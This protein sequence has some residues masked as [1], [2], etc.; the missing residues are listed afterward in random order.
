MM[1][2]E[3]AAL[4]HFGL[5]VRTLATSLAEPPL[6]PGRLFATTMIWVGVI[7]F[8]LV[9]QLLVSTWRRSARTHEP[10]L[11]DG[12]A[13]SVSLFCLCNGLMWVLVSPFSL[14]TMCVCYTDPRARVFSNAGSFSQPLTIFGADPLTRVKLASRP[15]TYALFRRFSIALC[16]LL[17]VAPCCLLS[18][19]PS[20]TSLLIPHNLYFILRI[21]SRPNSRPLQFD[22]LTSGTA[23]ALFLLGHVLFFYL[24]RPDPFRICCRV[25]FDIACFGSCYGGCAVI[26]PMRWIAL[27]L[28]WVE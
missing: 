21:L 15:Y 26:I 3:D 5:D 23:E 18:R 8:S 28:C 22:L 27:F 11:L 17:W 19:R 2:S 16:H 13:S 1:L 6:A 10:F 7:M 9:F 14:L 24:R 4:L 25:C 20:L 12:R